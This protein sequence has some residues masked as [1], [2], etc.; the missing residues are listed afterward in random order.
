MNNLKLNVGDN[1]RNVGY[2]IY[3]PNADPKASDAI[4][5]VIPD[6]KVVV[7]LF[8]NQQGE[9]WSV[10]FWSG[11]LDKVASYW[12]MIKSDR[13]VTEE[14]MSLL[15]SAFASVSRLFVEGKIEVFNL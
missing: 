4:R 8:D 13:I 12:R 3:T 11:D 1:L 15:E 5:I 6:L 2:V 14:E 10:K 9:L 7:K